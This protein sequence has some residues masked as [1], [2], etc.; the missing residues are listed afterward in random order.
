MY[1]IVLTT[2]QYVQDP[3]IVNVIGPF[4]HNLDPNLIQ[5]NSFFQDGG[6]YS[7]EDADSFPSGET[8]KREGAF[9]V[10]TWE[11]VRELL[12]TPIGG[13]DK[14]VADLFYSRFGMKPGGNVDKGKVCSLFICL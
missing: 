13:G 11:E 4:K 7:A 6:F 9:C 14:T 2:L 5:F 12:V 8:H 10:W 3:H 1:Y